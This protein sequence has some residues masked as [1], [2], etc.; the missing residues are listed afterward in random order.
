MGWLDDALAAVGEE[1]PQE[2][3]SLIPERVPGR[4]LLVD[5]DLM[6]Y[7]CAGNDELAPGFARMAAISRLENLR[8]MSGSERIVVHMTSESSTKGDR[9]IVATVKPYQGK[10]SSGRRPKNWQ[11]L[12]DWIQSYSGDLFK[13]KTW[14]DREADDSIAYHATVLGVDN[15]VI[16]TK[17]KDLRMIPG[18]HVNWDTYEM[19][20]LDR[21]FEVVSPTTGKVFGHKWFWLQLLHGDGV[22]NIPGLPKYVDDKGKAKLIGEKTAADQLAPAENDAQAF[23]I[24]AKLYHSWYKEEWADALVEQMALLW[25]RRDKEAALND[26]CSWITLPV[27]VHE[28]FEGLQTW[29]DAAK[30]AVNGTP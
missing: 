24:V 13:V 29:V 6:A 1:A 10:R 25:M 7:S 11:Y 26:V 15:C 8:D 3:T 28:A 23:C 12:R 14:G 16:A 21:E 30:E 9:Y 5:G 20:R 27:E 18:W 17:D 2:R 4:V 22:D 19:V